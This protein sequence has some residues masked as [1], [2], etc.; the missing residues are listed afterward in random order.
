M[1]IENPK[2]NSESESERSA[3]E[4]DALGD[5][6]TPPIG[7]RLAHH[8]KGSSE[9]HLHDGI[10]PLRVREA[11]PAVLLADRAN[12]L[13]GPRF[14][15]PRQGVPCSDGGKAR[16]HLRDDTLVLL[17]RTAGPCTQGALVERKAVDR[18]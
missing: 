6:E 13:R 3:Q 14:A 16:H 17:D 11:D 18:E 2:P 9:V 1:D 10:H 7:L 5:G 15:E 8:E 4:V 12:L